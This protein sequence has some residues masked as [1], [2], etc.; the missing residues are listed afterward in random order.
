MDPGVIPLGSRIMI[1]GFDNVFTAEDTG[2]AVRGNHIDIYF[3]DR[4]EAIRFGVQH[5]TVIILS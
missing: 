5:R 2:G 1:E 4:A 3:P